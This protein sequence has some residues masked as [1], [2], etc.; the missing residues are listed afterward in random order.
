M[1]FGE[2]GIGVTA[3]PYTGDSAVSINLQSQD[4]EQTIE[5]DGYNIEG[6]YEGYMT[7]YEGVFN[8]QALTSNNINTGQNAAQQNGVGLAANVDTSYGGAVSVNALS[9]V[10]TQD[11]IPT[12]DNI[13]SGGYYYGTM[14][15]HSG[16]FNNQAV[17]ANNINTGQNAAQQGAV[18]VAVSSGAGYP[19]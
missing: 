9:Q 12:D 14:T 2:E 1:S 8:N 19:Y 11:I 10:V 16:A 15:I 18:S 7:L 13:A 4:A 6:T 17:V 5:P 3:G